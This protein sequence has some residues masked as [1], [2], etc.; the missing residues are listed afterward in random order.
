[1]QPTRATELTVPATGE[2]KLVD[3]EG[4]HESSQKGRHRR[5]VHA[6]VRF[7]GACWRI[8]KRPQACETL[9]SASDAHRK[10]CSARPAASN[11]D[12]RRAET[13]ERHRLAV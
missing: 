4:A 3:V 10:A 9:K 5:P 8:D 13:Q 1:M 6:F 11:S 7:T 2:A 12:A